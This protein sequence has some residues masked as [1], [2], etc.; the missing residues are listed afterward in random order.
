MLD[1]WSEHPVRPVP[2]RCPASVAMAVDPAHRDRGAID[3]A[4][5]AV[6][7]RVCQGF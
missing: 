7:V 4:V 5:V 1:R 3:A 6:G 2:L